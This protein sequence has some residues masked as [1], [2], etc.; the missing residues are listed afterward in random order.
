MRLA[1]AV[2]AMFMTMAQAAAPEAFLAPVVAAVDPVRMALAPDEGER[3]KLSLLG[4]NDRDGNWNRMQASYDAG[5]LGV[6]RIRYDRST[7]ASHA[8]IL[9]E[10]A[11]AWTIP[12]ARQRYAIVRATA[13]QYSGARDTRVELVLAVMF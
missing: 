7:S 6:M 9:H 10:R 2:A 11:V 13:S 8:A 5:D 4:T 12:F 1:I 3:L